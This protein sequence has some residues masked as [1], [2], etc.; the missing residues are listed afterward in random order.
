MS[1]NLKRGIL[2]SIVFLLIGGILFG[3]FILNREWEALSR[4]TAEQVVAQTFERRKEHVVPAALPTSVVI[5]SSSS[6]FS[7]VSTASVSAP[8]V[9]QEEIAILLLG[10]D[11]RQHQTSAHCDAIHL[12]TLNTIEKTIK[13]T[14]IPRGTYVYI[15]PGIYP[16]SDSYFANACKWAGI[17]YLTKQVEKLLNTQVDYT[18]KV[19]FS[20]TLG[21]L[22]ALQL[23]TTDSLRW[24]RAR[25]SF[26]IGDNQRSH[27]Q[28]VF[29]KDAILKK[30]DMFKNPMW[31]PVAKVA[32][33]YVDTD[34][35]F[36]SAYA[37]LRFYAESDLEN[38]PERIKLAMKP[39]RI[40]ED[41]HFDF[42]N[43]EAT[44]NKYPLLRETAT[45]NRGSKSPA[46]AETQREVVQN[47]T[48]QL[49]THG[50]LV[51][52]VQKKLWLQ[53]EDENVREDLYFKI[54]TRLV[55]GEQN[56]EKKIDLVTEY[57]QEKEALGLLEWA[58]KGKGL[59]QKVAYIP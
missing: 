7:I 48:K 42:D 45:S 9:P 55:E 16:Q 25:K 31:F 13:I 24:L 41:L 43:P 56:Q 35:D 38:H 6:D 51:S 40:T 14:S 59:V 15:P 39:H 58:D 11:S 34:L 46:L 44:F 32:Y 26:I 21:I 50:S 36:E 22:R 20:Q 19:G 5:S 54:I 18:V 2:L 27:N 57:I 37:L 29:M 47:I 23:P 52:I 33:S 8:K 28:A 1:K 53:I 12:F 30:L 17:P 10:L 3:S 49:N 4:V